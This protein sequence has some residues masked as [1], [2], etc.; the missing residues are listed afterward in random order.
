MSSK[1]RPTGGETPG[2]ETPERISGSEWDSV[3][4]S[5]ER[6]DDRDLENID[7]DIECVN[8][9]LERKARQ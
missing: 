9:A 5:F 1:R 3:A 6:I 2:G 4:T 7:L 8:E